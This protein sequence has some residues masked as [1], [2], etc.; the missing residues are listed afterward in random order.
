MSINFI[1]VRQS[2]IF[3][4]FQ[5]CPA[6]WRD[7]PFD[8]APFGSELFFDTESQDE[9][10]GR[11]QGSELVELPLAE[12]LELQNQGCGKSHPANGG[13]S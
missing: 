12:R 1:S 6:F 2:L 7:P 5:A 8:F 9:V 10:Q 4:Y 11:R 13:G 3:A